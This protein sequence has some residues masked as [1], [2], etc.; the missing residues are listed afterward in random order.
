MKWW[1]AFYCRGEV[2]PQ[3]RC[4]VQCNNCQ[5]TI[6]EAMIRLRPTHYPVPAIP[7]TVEWYQGQTLPEQTFCVIRDNADNVTAVW[8]T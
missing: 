4:R 3:A 2:T 6:G 7:L 5:G 8:S 1:Q